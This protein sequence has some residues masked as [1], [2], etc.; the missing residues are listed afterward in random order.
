MRGG[1]TAIR[2]ACSPTMGAGSRTGL[3]FQASLHGGD[4]AFAIEKRGRNSPTE[5]IEDE[6]SNAERER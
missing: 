2:L 5:A 1:N 4:Q 3:T 6:Q